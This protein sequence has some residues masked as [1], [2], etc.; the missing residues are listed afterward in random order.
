MNKYIFIVACLMFSACQ[1]LP[2]TRLHSTT[3]IAAN[4]AFILGNNQ[5]GSFSVNLKNISKTEVTAWRCPIGGGQ[6]SPVQVKPNEEL[7]I[8]VEKNTALR[9]DNASEKT[10]NVQLKITGDVGLSMGY[11]NP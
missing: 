3:T 5:H 1:Y 10:V 8:R 2:F 9:I 6:H 11:K 7:F 4:N